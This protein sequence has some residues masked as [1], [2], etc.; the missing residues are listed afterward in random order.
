[1]SVEF[2]E[3]V[4]SVA[5]VESGEPVDSGQPVMKLFP[6][7]AVSWD[8]DKRERPGPAVRIPVVV[9]ERGETMCEMSQEKQD[10][11][12]F[13]ICIFGL[14]YF[15]ISLVLVHDSKD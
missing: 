11:N 12:I 2:I 8:I 15:R 13:V 1:V 6:A 14:M 10:I 3:P 9:L 4:D 5:P 7:V